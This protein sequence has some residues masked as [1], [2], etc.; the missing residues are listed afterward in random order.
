MRSLF[1]TSFA[2][3]FLL[4]LLPGAASAE[5]IRRGV[6]GGFRSAFVFE[7]GTLIGD[8]LWAVLALA[9]AAVLVQ[10]RLVRV[11]LSMV[12]SRP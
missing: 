8:A 4:C 7:L 11:A 2:L 1:A 10:N 3:G 6:R 12:G 9:G 5:A